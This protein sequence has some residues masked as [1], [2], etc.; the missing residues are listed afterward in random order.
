MY[1]GNST[2]YTSHGHLPSPKDIDRLDLVPAPAPPHNQQQQQQQQLKLPPGRCP[3]RSGFVS[4]FE[5]AAASA[6]T[7][8][9]NIAF[10]PMTAQ[11]AKCSKLKI[12]IHFD[13]TIFQ[14]GGNL[15]GRM[16]IIASSSR[17]LK[18]GEIS[19]ELAAY[20]EISSRDLTATQSFLSSR[21]CFQSTDIPPSNAVYGPYDEGGFWMAKKGKTTF[22][23]AFQL[24]LDCPSSLVFGQT[25]SL[26]YVVTGL[27]QVFYHGKEETI[28][29]SK[30]A[31]VVEAWDGYNPDYK[32]PVHAT[33]STKL[34][35]GGSGSLV[36]E[37]RIAERLHNAGG[38]LTV[39]VKVRNNTSRKVQGIRLGVARRLEMV[40]DKAQAERNPGLQIDTVSVSEVIGTQD[41]KSSSF[42]FDTGEERSTTVNMIIPGNARTIRGTALFEVTCYVVVSVP[43][44][45]FSG[46]LSVEIPVKICHPASLTPAPKPKLEQNHLPHHYNL[47]GDDMDIESDKRGRTTRRVGSNESLMMPYGGS[48]D[49]SGFKSHDRDNPW[50]SE[51][52]GVSIGRQGE[53]DGDE[54]QLSPA[55]S[56]TSIRSILSSPKQ[57][58]SKLA[59]KI[60][61]STSPSSSGHLQHEH[62]RGSRNR[63]ESDPARRFIK[64]PALGP[65]MPIAYVPAVERVRYTPF[66][67]PPTTKAQEFMKA[68]EKYHQ[69]MAHCGIPGLEDDDTE[70]DLSDKTV[71][72]AIHSW[73]SKKE[74]EVV[75]KQHNQAGIAA[76]T[77]TRPTPPIPIPSV[78]PGRRRPTVNR[79]DTQ[80]AGSFTS[81][82]SQMGA[83]PQSYYSPASPGGGASPT[84]LS[85]PQPYSNQTT[86]RFIHHAH[87][88]PA[89]P[90]TEAFGSAPE[91]CT[92][93]PPLFARP[94]PLPSPPPTGSPSRPGELPSSQRFPRPASPIGV[95]LQTPESLALAREAYE[96]VKRAISPTPDALANA[97][98]PTSARDAPSSELQSSSAPRAPASPQPSEN[99]PVTETPTPLQRTD[100]PR[101]VASSPSGL[102]RL[103]NK[104]GESGVDPRMV[105]AGQDDYP[106]SVSSVSSHLQ[107]RNGGPS[108]ELGA[109][110]SRAQLSSS[111]NLSHVP[112]NRP[113]PIPGPKPRHTNPSGTFT[114]SST[115]QVDNRTNSRELQRPGHSIP[116]PIPAP[117]ATSPSRLSGS[118]QSHTSSGH[119]SRQLQP[120]QTTL[121]SSPSATHQIMRSD[122]E[123]RTVNPSPNQTQSAIHPVKPIKPVKPAKPA[124]PGAPAL[125]A[126]TPPPPGV[127]S[128][129]IV[130]SKP[131]ALTSS[132]AKPGM[133]PSTSKPAGAAAGMGTGTATGAGSGFIYP[134]ATRKPVVGIKPVVAAKPK[135][136]PIPN[137]PT[138]SDPVILHK[139]QNRGTVGLDPRQGV[140]SS[141]TSSQP[142]ATV[143][144]PQYIPERIAR[145]YQE[146]ESMAVLVQ[147]ESNSVM[148]AESR[149]DLAVDPG[150]ESGQETIAFRP[151]VVE[152]TTTTAS[153]QLESNLSERQA[154]GSALQNLRPLKVEQHV[155]S[156]QDHYE[157]E[158][159]SAQEET[160][161]QTRLQTP[162]Q[163]LAVPGLALEP[164]LEPEQYQQQLP[165][166]EE[167]EE[168]VEHHETSSEIR[169]QAI[170][171]AH[172]FRA[173]GA[174]VNQGGYAVNTGK[175]RQVIQ[176][177]RRS[178]QTSTGSSNSG[179]GYLIQA[180]T[181]SAISAASAASAV[182]T[183][184]L[185][186]RN[187][188][189]QQQ[190]QH[191]DQQAREG[192]TAAERPNSGG[193]PRTRAAPGQQSSQRQILPEHDLTMKDIHFQTVGPSDRVLFPT[194]ER[195][196][197]M[198]QEYGQRSHHL[199]GTTSSIVVVDRIP[200]MS[201]S[202]PSSR[203]IHREGA[204]LDEEEEE[205]QVRERKIEARSSQEQV[206]ARVRARERSRATKKELPTRPPIRELSPL[207]QESIPASTTVALA[208][209]VAEAVSVPPVEAAIDNHRRM[210]MPTD[211]YST[212]AFV[213]SGPAMS[214]MTPVGSGNE[215]V[216]L[217]DGGSRSG[218][219]V[220]N[221]DKTLPKI[222]QNI[223]TAATGAAAV[224][225]SRSRVFERP[226]PSTTGC[227]GVT[228]MDVE[229][230]ASTATSTVTGIGVGASRSRLGQSTVGGNGGSVGTGPGGGF[231]TK[232]IN[233]K[234][235]AYI[236]KY[237]QATQQ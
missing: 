70:I 31:F 216:L 126:Y 179:S 137:P 222:Q 76:P 21:L 188:S 197:D 72:S 16:E 174:M 184:G 135:I 183:N 106:E 85:G 75:R 78:S 121:S 186:W 189:P 42:L 132:R 223:S 166:E 62:R 43:L 122:Y 26:R 153:T 56:I 34:F 51:D 130:G 6:L 187:P 127:A 28:L 81:Q 13:S 212:P 117:R 61:R 148:P 46:D 158:S 73:I 140:P 209:V 65:A 185:G 190:Q 114:N 59:D 178:S 154:S 205:K 68:A 234:L 88:Q 220:L 196:S 198:E 94:L 203:I 171:A 213:D 230:A 15:F 5:A 33:N 227:E 77:A 175:L 10:R 12:R 159:I 48:G 80:L 221:L 229:A 182:V 143:R 14:A 142:S 86:S 155:S 53:W 98:T 71:A 129:P 149:G 64:S 191:Q 232:P 83:S 211:G 102:S 55:N 177:S 84:S 39:D 231:G 123:W 97:T 37:A 164:R 105:R 44:G 202:Q 52:A 92:V 237:N 45:A 3:R 49:G 101:E 181:D 141:R 195:I 90:Q 17:S 207:G 120:T 224:V 225:I 151:P 38:H 217:T 169:A 35:W 104:N 176:D 150:K 157:R 235:Q 138:R 163:S 100:P 111:P 134:K 96:R 107:S 215:V 208:N 119:L 18:L 218:S 199:M 125:A 112:M 29:K 47:V 95:P 194:T 27:V 30:E 60:Q 160:L 165:P 82:H 145:E 74:S 23:F 50:G 168:I 162:V 11:P 41:F 136:L 40:S 36:L 108:N 219:K 139:E 228:R 118:P 25:A 57:K 8:A 210:M 147:R 128:K 89:A 133:M 103:L 58:L 99:H 91:D 192:V 54:P 20:E 67:P 201:R 173:T 69:E 110:L 206:I 2:V 66:Q 9:N 124:K 193:R 7:L 87:R 236:Q 79:I 200:A 170:A 204:I 93:T 214:L 161:I 19:V 226:L 144:A 22:P 233:P 180:I 63:E 24:P 152:P 116:L 156:V 113:L 109:N 4:G 131:G 32:L 115:L 1:Y 167:A 146:E 172:S